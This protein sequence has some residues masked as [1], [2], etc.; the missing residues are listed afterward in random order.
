[1]MEQYL[2][3]I[4]GGSFTAVLGYFLKT[5]MDDLRKVKEVAN[6]A[7][8]DINILKVDHMNKYDHLTDKFDELAISV[9]DLTKEIKDLNK[10]LR[11]KD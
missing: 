10:E 1:M 8:N 7:K 6:E 3:N 4:L 5:T 11:K 9:K 2:F